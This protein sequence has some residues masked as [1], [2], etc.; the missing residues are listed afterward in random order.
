MSDQRRYGLAFDDVAMG[1]RA[2]R[3]TSEGLL[4]FSHGPWDFV[5]AENLRESVL[6]LADL[7]QALGMLPAKHRPELGAA[8]G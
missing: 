5:H 8:P 6:Q 7:V 3:L 4:G 2:G 1:I